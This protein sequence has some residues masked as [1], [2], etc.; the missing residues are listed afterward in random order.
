MSYFNKFPK[1]PYLFGDK[2]EISVIQNIAAY[3]DMLDELSQNNAFYNDFYIRNGDRPDQISYKLYDDP[4]LHWLFYLTNPKLREQGWPL[5][6]SELTNKIKGD[7]T[8][9]TITTLDADLFSKF[10]MGQ[11]VNS[12]SGS[13]TIVH[14]NIALGQIVLEDVSGSFTSTGLLTSVDEHGI[15]ETLTPVSV[16]PEFMSAH[17]YEDGEGNIVDIDPTTGPGAQITEVTHLQYYVRQN[18]ALRNIRV[19]RPT[20]VNSVLTRFRQALLS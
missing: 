7:F 20:A 2:E 6:T 18:E 14:R 17:H 19:I 1:V 9:T 10:A 16:G 8:G 15:T 11:T 3:V 4:Q 13:G 5:G 12:A